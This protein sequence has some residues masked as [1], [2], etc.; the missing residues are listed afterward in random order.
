[1]AASVRYYT[2]IALRSRS[3][4]SLKEKCFKK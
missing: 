2:V 3:R 4:N 1:L